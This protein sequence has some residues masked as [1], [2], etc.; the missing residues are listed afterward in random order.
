MMVCCHVYGESGVVNFVSCTSSELLPGFS[1]LY[2][3]LDRK[4]AFVLPGA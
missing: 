2:P 3:W 1:G 4:T